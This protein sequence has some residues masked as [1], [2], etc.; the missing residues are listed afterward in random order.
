MYVIIYEIFIYVCIIML[1]GH[2]IT[3]AKAIHELIIIHEL[4]KKYKNKYESPIHSKT[5]QDLSFL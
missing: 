4:S 1:Y 2:V 5:C 3:C